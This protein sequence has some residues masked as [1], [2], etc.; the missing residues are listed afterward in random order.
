MTATIRVAAG[1]RFFLP[2]R[3]RH[4]DVEVPVDGTSTVLHVVEALGVPRTEFGPPL[5]NGRPA[6]T[7]DRPRDGDVIDV[8]D[9]PRPQPVPAERFVLD[10]HL[11]S[12]ARRL[13]L[14]GIDTAYPEE[15]GDD[16]LVALAIAEGRVLLTKDRG[17]LRRRALP[18][19]AFVRGDGPEAELADVLDR[20]APRVSPWSRCPACNGRLA[21]VAKAEVMDQL[22][23][24]T[25]RSYDQF[26]RC[27]DCGRVY[28]RGAHGEG[29]QAVL[30]AASIGAAPAEHR[31][32][33]LPEDG[34]IRGE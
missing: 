9:R 29:L 1:L 8:P 15:A 16:A 10:V 11:G 25:R 14:L 6:G 13:R 2:P 19:G 20:F 7:D 28:W 26:S 34:Q 23:P 4:G 30:D 18:D 3:H 12:L 5:V 22:L 31:A 24:G 27:G 17:I 32:E 21:P 33:R